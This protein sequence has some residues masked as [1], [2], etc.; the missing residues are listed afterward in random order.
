MLPRNNRCL[1]RSPSAPRHLAQP[2]LCPQIPAIPE[3]KQVSDGSSSP[4]GSA[5]KPAR[6]PRS[7]RAGSAPTTLLE[8]S[9]PEE[10]A[11]SERGSPP[12]VHEKK[13]SSAPCLSAKQV[14]HVA[15]CDARSVSHAHLASP[16]VAG[17]VQPGQALQIQVAWQ[18]PASLGVEDWPSPAPGKLLLRESRQ[19]EFRLT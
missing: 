9:R 1:D 15:V 10:Q 6:G 12:T 2:G 14:E 3:N 7:D 19:Q 8:L 18:S 5:A 11:R 16:A 4:T 13:R 17:S